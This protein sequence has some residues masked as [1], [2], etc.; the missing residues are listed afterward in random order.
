MSKIPPHSYSGLTAY[1][2]CPRRYYLTRVSR[3][4][5][6]PPGEAA[7]WGTTVHSAMESRLK[8]GTPLPP[9]L[10]G[11]ESLAVMLTTKQGKR[12]IE[13][14]MAV[15][16]GFRPVGWTDP[17]AWFRAI[18]DFALV[19]PQSAVLLDWK[20]GK[21]KPDMSQL[22]LSS[23]VAF[24]HFPYV[25]EV[26]TMYVWLKDKKLDKE[27]INIDQR[28]GLWNDLQPRVQRLELA[29]RDNKWEPKPSGLCGVWCPV[30]KRHCEF[31][32]PPNTAKFSE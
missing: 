15:D 22:K 10:G 13:H 28:G 1:E 8:N 5:S 16:R 3:E 12:L 29:Y 26:H 23:A 19:G 27:I 17:K 4:V 30:T 20:T 32:R 6:D 31:G 14:K 25:K 7:K 18:V 2:T 24:S 21:R 9:S 11:Y